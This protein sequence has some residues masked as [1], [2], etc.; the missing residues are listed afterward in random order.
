MVLSRWTWPD[1]N[2]YWKPKTSNYQDPARDIKSTKN[3]REMVAKDETLHK[4]W[5]TLF[6]IF[7]KIEISNSV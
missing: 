6:W 5:W 2:G 3:I 7:D 4:Q 1:Q